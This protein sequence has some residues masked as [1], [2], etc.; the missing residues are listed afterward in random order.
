MLRQKMAEQCEL[1]QPSWPQNLSWEAQES[2]T[3]SVYLKSQPFFETHV[4]CPLE[5]FPRLFQ[6]DLQTVCCCVI[7]HS[8]T[9]FY[10]HSTV[11]EYISGRNRVCVC[12]CFAGMRV[13]LSQCLVM[14]WGCSRCAVINGKVVRASTCP[15]SQ[16]FF[17]SRKIHRLQP[18]IRGPVA[19][20]CEE[21]YPKCK[22]SPKVLQKPTRKSQSALNPSWGPDSPCVDLSV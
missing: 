19:P 4:L 6:W 8:P 1:Q 10:Y 17:S 7:L 22:F 14:G 20:G 11:C 3:T 21:S 12:V 9:P 16:T 5:N 13:Q 15:N 2:G 18:Q